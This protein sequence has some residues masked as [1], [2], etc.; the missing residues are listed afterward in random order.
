M[1]HMVKPAEDFEDERFNFKNITLI[2][3]KLSKKNFND[4]VYEIIFKPLKMK[5]TSFILN[6]K[7]KKHIALQYLY[8]GNKNLLYPPTKI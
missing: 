1:L 6:D 8:D 4:Y 7:N 3:E 5:N 2:I